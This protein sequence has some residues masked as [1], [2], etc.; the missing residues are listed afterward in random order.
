MLQEM[1]QLSFVQEEK[2]REAKQASPC[3][4]GQG[5]QKQGTVIEKAHLILWQ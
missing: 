2:H 5:P 3:H 1:R 4:S